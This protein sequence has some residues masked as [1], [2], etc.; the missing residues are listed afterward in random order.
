MKWLLAWRADANERDTV[1]W[2]PLAWAA[3]RNDARTCQVLLEGRADA[4]SIGQ[5]GLSALSLAYRCSHSEV[6]EIL[7]TAG[8][9]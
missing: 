7:L 4:D 6:V 9:D 2:T 5:G 8:A 3:K 1:G